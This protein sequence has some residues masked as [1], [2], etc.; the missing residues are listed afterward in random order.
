MTTHE[1][2]EQDRDLVRWFAEERLGWEHRQALGE[3]WHSVEGAPI[4]HQMRDLLGWPGFGLA[5][6]EARKAEMRI[7]MDRDFVHFRVDLLREAWLVA[8]THPTD[9]ALAAYAALRDALG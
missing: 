2:T 3:C 8:R 6:E 9:P 5:V 1:L 7:R 4:C